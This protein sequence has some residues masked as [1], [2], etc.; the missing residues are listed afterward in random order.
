MLTNVAFILKINLL[1]E[2][3]GSDI[4]VNDFFVLECETVTVV[5]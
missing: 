5:Y 3:S 1:Y 4:G 2:I